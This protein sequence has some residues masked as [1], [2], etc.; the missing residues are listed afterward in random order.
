MV[1]PENESH[2]KYVRIV[3]QTTGIDSCRLQPIIRHHPESDYRVAKIEQSYLN[4]HKIFK[5][6][7]Y[8]KQVRIASE[9]KRQGSMG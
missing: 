9:R 6:D 7:E 4:W 2:E 3:R 5:T 1:I 8:L